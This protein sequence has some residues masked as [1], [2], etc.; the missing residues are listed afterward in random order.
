MSYQQARH[1][2]VPTRGV[3]VA[4][5]GYVF[6]AAGIPRGAV[7]MT[8]N[9]R[10]TDTLRDF[11][12]GVAQLAD[13]ERAPGGYMTIPDPHNNELRALPLDR[14]WFSPRPC[15]LADASRPW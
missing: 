10:K 6:G 4:N 3:Y 11:E 5:P 14:P 2:N 15:D 9:G 7:L 12:A 1:F 8:I 13:G